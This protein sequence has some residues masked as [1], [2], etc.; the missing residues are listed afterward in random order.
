MIRVLSIA[1]AFMLVAAPAHAAALAPLVAGIKAIAGTA[2]GGFVL[3]TAASFALSALSVALK[4]K[5]ERQ[6][7]GIQTEQTLTGGVNPDSFAIGYY[8]TAGVAVCPTL[9]HTVGGT[10]NNMVTY[11][12]E[13]GCLPVEGL[14]Q[15]IVSG[16]PVTIGNGVHADYGKEIEGDYQDRMWIKFYDGTQTAADPMMLDKYGDDP[17]FPWSADMI[18]RN[19]PYAIITE[20]YESDKWN[21]FSAFRFALSGIKLYDVRKDSSAGGAG[22]HRWNDPA[23]YEYSTNPAVMAYNILRGID[24]PN[25]DVWGG[26]AGAEDLPVSVWAAAMNEC[27]IDVPRAEGGTEPQYRAGFEVFLDQEPAAILE[28]LLAACSGEVVEDGGTWYIRVGPPSLPVYFLTDKDVLVSEARELDP[29]PSLNETINGVRASF[30]NPDASWEMSDAPAHYRSDLEAEDRNRRLATDLTLEACPYGLQAQRLARAYVEDA[31]RFRRH[32]LTLPCDAAFVTPLQ[33]VSWS[34]EQNRYSAKLFEATRRTTELRGLRSQFVLRERDPSD[35]DWHSDY[36]LPSDYPPVNRTPPAPL[37]LPGVGLFAIKIGDEAGEGRRPALKLTWTQVDASSVSWE[38]RVKSTGSMVSQGTSAA[39]VSGEAVFSD[40][41]LPQTTYEVRALVN[42]AGA[43]DWTEWLEATTDAVYLGKKDIAPPLIAQIDKA[44]QD[45]VKAQD[46]ADAVA[47]KHNALTAGFSGRLDAAFAA[48][49]T[50]L[51]NAVSGI[52]SDLDALEQT[53]RARINS[54]SATLT[55]SHYTIAQADQAIANATQS[56]QSSLESPS[57]S[58]GSLSARLINDYMTSTQTGEAIAAARTSLGAEI[59]NLRGAVPGWYSACDSLGVFHR[60]EGAALSSGGAVGFAKYTT[61]TDQNKTLNTGGSTSGDVVF[62]LGS[63]YERQF[64]A[65]RIKISVLARKSPS[66]SASE[67]GLA[68]STNDNGNSGF[69]QSEPLQSDWSWFSFYYNVPI[70]KN[71]GNDYIGLFAGDAPGTGKR[72]DVAVVSVQISA[73]A[74]DLPEIEQITASLDDIQGLEVTSDTAFGTFLS[75]LGVAANGVIAGVSSFGSAVADMLGR[76]SAAYAFR[77][78]AGQNTAEL[79]LV[80]WDDTEGGG[81]AIRAN[82]A[83]FIAD[84]SITTPLLTVTD[85]TNYAL[86]CDFENEAAL[87]FALKSNMALSSSQ[88]KNG[89]KSLQITGSS[90]TARF[91]QTINVSPGERILV[92]AWAKRDGA[93]AGT[94]GG[95]KIR[96][97]NATPGA[98]NAYIAGLDYGAGSLSTSWAELEKSFNVPD[99]CTQ[100]GV[101]IYNT[102][103]GG[104]KCWL[105]DI[106]IR[107]MH[108]G[109]LV[110]DGSVKTRHLDAASVTADK[111]TFSSGGNFIEDSSFLTGVHRVGTHITDATLE[112]QTSISIR[113]PGESWASASLPTLE[114]KQ[115]G[116]H[117]PS[118]KYVRTYLRPLGSDSN[119]ARGLPCYGGRYYE[120]HARVSTHRCDGRL[121]IMWR[122]RAGTHISSDYVALDMDNSGSSSHPEHWKLYRVKARAPAGATHYSVVIEKNPTRSGSTSSY[123]FVFQPYSAE[124]SP[125]STE[126]APYSVGA[127]TNSMSSDNYVPRKSGWAVHSDGSAEFKNMVVRDWIQVGAGSDRLSYENFSARGFDNNKVAGSLTLGPTSADHMWHITFSGRWR[128]RSQSYHCQWTSQGDYNITRRA[129]RT[130][131]QLQYRT[132]TGSSWTS[133]KTAYTSNKSVYSNSSWAY[134]EGDPTFHIIGNY[135]NVEVRVLVRTEE[136]NIGSS[137][138]SPTCTGTSGTYTNVDD[139]IIHAEATVI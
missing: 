68:Y 124:T 109:E 21:G 12:I 138:G 72:F 2:F 85:P 94:S 118:G 40:G 123:I 111:I 96:F 71:G 4:G 103:N 80:A 41:I 101:Q 67:F 90:G 133:W 24:L 39:V 55:N 6:T 13:L 126:P 66:N 19:R 59:S 91:F 76:A 61:V 112:Q 121:K 33:C 73:E 49:D 1:M 93:W 27:D 74:D 44:A 86:G 99:G 54:V 122:N 119:I 58:I 81:A 77:V 75:Q 28:K 36:E 56:L 30:P 42:L 132:K 60:A 95:N 29:W 117:R 15:L 134:P 11:V 84:K 69:M 25:G 20:K 97:Y 34:S 22:S 9:T 89:T 98:N 37:V 92:Q 135:D 105:D 5:P 100:L 83:R 70:R 82:G 32:T 136:G 23:T 17:D 113:R 63:E 88:K 51:A 8:A 53:L 10:P 110:V 52:D 128:R 50:A 116:S 127:V 104:G 26:E 114:I 62:E 65:R 129:K 87:P 16:E 14:S 57:G 43:R 3:K 79:E 35:Y 48:R 108:T 107:K 31:R 130:Y 106:R 115:S 38:C 139:I 78:A 45:A 7:R 18:G 137:S 120:F 47:A 102:T 131:I 64:S 125:H 46:A